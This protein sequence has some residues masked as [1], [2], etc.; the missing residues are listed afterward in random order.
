MDRRQFGCH[1][2]DF[3]YP[4]EED[5]SSVYD[6]CCMCGKHIYYGDLYGR[7]GNDVYCEECWGDMLEYADEPAID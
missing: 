1:D 7:I 2:E 3:W 4:T 5:S 6:D